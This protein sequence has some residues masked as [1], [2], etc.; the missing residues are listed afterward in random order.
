ML[1]LLTNRLIISELVGSH[2]LRAYEQIKTLSN[3]TCRRWNHW[4]LRKR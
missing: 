3:L 1:S 4:F 2:C